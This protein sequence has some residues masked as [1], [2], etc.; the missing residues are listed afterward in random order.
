MKDNDS[1]MK[2]PAR[3]RIACLTHKKLYIYI[4]IHISIHICIYTYVYIYIYVNVGRS[5]G[6]SSRVGSVGSGLIELG[7]VG[8]K[9]GRAL[10]VYMNNLPETG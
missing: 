6:R 5:V 4:Y 3:D 9:S 8:S 10:D 7:A 1:Q 2:G